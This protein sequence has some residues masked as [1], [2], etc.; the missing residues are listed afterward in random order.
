MGTGL[1]EVGRS[2]DIGLGQVAL[3]PGLVPVAD[4]QLLP[5]VEPFKPL[6]GDILVLGVD[7]LLDCFQFS[8]IHGRQ[9]GI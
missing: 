1:Q 3:D 4:G 5:V 6:E 2:D 7:Q 9:L 8:N